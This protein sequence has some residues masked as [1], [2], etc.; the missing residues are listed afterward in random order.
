MLPLATTRY[1]SC[2]ILAHYSEGQSSLLNMTE[3]SS[4]EGVVFSSGIEKSLALLLDNISISNK[5]ISVASGILFI[6][7]VVE[8]A[9]DLHMLLP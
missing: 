4:C 6:V 2:S 5:S 1:I 8:Y 9:A 3:A 7:A